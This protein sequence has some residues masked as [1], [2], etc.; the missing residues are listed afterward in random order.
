MNDNVIAMDSALKA[1]DMSKVSAAVS[2]YSKVWESRTFDFLPLLH[3]S[4]ER[5][6]K[7]FVK[8]GGEL[9]R[10]AEEISASINSENVAELLKEFQDAGSDADEQAFYLEEI[11][12]GAKAI[13][14]KLG[15][16]VGGV[17][18]ATKSIASLPV[19]DVERDRASYIE[20]QQR[21]VKALQE[22]NEA[23]ASK[24][25]EIAELDKAIAVFEENGIEKLFEGKLPTTEQVQGMVAQGSTTAGAAVAVEQALEALNKLLG[26]IQEGMRYSQLQ[27]RR[28]EFQSQAQELLVEQREQQ[29]KE[30]Q[31]SSYIESLSVH[32]SLVEKRSEWLSQKK[33]IH[34]QLQIELN[35]LSGMSLKGAE[36]AQ[37]LSKQLVALATYVNHIVNKSREAF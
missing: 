12:R 7:G 4:I 20:T 31:V 21:L 1:P 34:A 17:D 8:F 14:S 29:K 23:M 35:K 9:A 6:Y 25:K 33:Q 28:R 27:E 24:Q 3:T 16:L 26:G 19:Y 5:H 37:V 22:L 30:K 10:N 13:S 11:Q 32:A 2:A 18:A 15:K 36:Q